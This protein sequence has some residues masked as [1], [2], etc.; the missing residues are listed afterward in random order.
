MA[1]A[2]DP[3]AIERLVASPRDGFEGKVAL[4]SVAPPGVT[5]ALAL[6]LAARGATPIIAHRDDEPTADDTIA[7][8]RRQGFA[9]LAMCGDPESLREIEQMFDTVAER[10]GRLDFF[11]CDSLPSDAR[12]VLELQP[13]QLESPF[14]V[15]MRAVVVGAQRARRL[16][17]RGGRIVVLTR[18]ASQRAFPGGANF[19]SARAAAE[20]WAKSMAVELA[21]HG[22]NVNIVAL[23]LVEPDIPTDTPNAGSVASLEAIAPMIP[24]RRVGSAQE[25]ADT[26]LFLLSPASE[27][28]TGATL[29]MDGGLTASWYVGGSDLPAV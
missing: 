8:I 14:T 9:A 10:F 13:E 17:D 25:V 28:V 11:V 6:S 22:I 1:T 5:R 3:G 23:G 16:M 12:P 21:P 26:V 27:Y 15:N 19:Q 7:E 18:C 2:V 4:L 24:K 20:Q 29:L